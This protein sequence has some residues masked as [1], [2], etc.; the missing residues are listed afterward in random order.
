M[1]VSGGRPGGVLLD[2]D[3]TLLDTSY[4]HVLAWWQALREA[5][6]R[7]VTMAAVH[8]AIG[9]ASRELVQR[10]VGSESE[11]AVEAHSRRYNAMTD[12]VVAFPGA[13]ELV[14]RCS[15]AGLRVV[16]ATSGVRSDLDWMLPAIGVKDAI[17]GA[18]TSEDVQRS[19]PA[20]DL[21]ATA[22]RNHDLDVE[23]T[24]AIGDTVWDVQSAR[25][26]GVPCVAFTSGGI[27]RADLTTAG[28]VEV[29]EGP[30][31]LLDHWDGSVLRRLV[32]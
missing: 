10:L 13:A 1:N 9:I 23:R 4:M 20:P 25:G 12:Q 26:A 3:G 27:C 21:L 28:A 5:G 19:K 29:F 22:V 14:R 8:R 24:A 17:A 18:T 2:V 16:L 31:D 7:D 15:G 11:A 32:R 30:Q 6:F